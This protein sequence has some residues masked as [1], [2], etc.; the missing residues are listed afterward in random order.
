MELDMF[1]AYRTTYHLNAKEKTR[2]KTKKNLCCRVSLCGVPHAKSDDGGPVAIGP[3][4]PW[5]LDPW[6]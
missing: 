4:W 3:S 2:G 6:R 5:H 1:L